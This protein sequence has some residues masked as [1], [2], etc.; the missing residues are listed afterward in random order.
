MASK[1][2]QFTERLRE[3]STDLD[4]F[5]EVTEFLN[6]TID[7]RTWEILQDLRDQLDEYESNTVFLAVSLKIMTGTLVRCTSCIV[8]RKGGPLVVILHKNPKTGYF[9]DIWD[10]NGKVAYVLRT[11]SSG[12]CA[13]EYCDVHDRPHPN[14]PLRD[15]P[16]N[17][18]TDAGKM[19]RICECGIGHTTYAQIEYWKSQGDFELLG[20]HG[21]CGHC[22]FDDTITEG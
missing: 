5:L 19:E 8:S 20:V 16:L 7:E 6:D 17:W 15:A 4:D 9:T 13:T 12:E 14:D 2:K 18:R 10:D 3:L 11:H 21:C 22:G 1:R